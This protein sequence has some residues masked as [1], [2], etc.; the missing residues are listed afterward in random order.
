MSIHRRKTND[1]R[2]KAV[3]DDRSFVLR[4]SSFVVIGY[5]NDLRGDDGVG[6]RVA[7]LVDELALPGVRAIAARQL[8]PELAARLAGSSLA[9]FVDACRLA[10]EPVDGAAVQVSQ[11]APAADSAAL[12]H[13]SDPRA[14]L[15]LSLT[16]YGYAPP[17]W[18]ISVP[19][20]TF[21]LGAPLSP[22]AEQG[23]LAAVRQI[24]ELLTR[25]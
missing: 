7:E 15:T 11:I 5:G 8:T 4:P 13:T 2:R 16:L 18:L 22:I 12:G 21:D 23:A 25:A 19:A 24:G 6:P 10:A 20:L 14:L 17:A 1:Q 9:L 3:E